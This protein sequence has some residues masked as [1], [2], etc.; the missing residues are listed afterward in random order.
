MY[1]TGNNGNNGNNNNGN[2]R[3]NN[4]N[5]DGFRIEYINESE[6]GENYRENYQVEQDQQTGEF[7][8]LDFEKRIKFVIVKDKLGYN[9]GNYAVDN[10][11]VAPYKATRE[12]IDGEVDE[13][14]QGQ[15]E[16]G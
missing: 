11:A 4:V 12:V 6:L 16:E 7:Y 1:I 3:G 5:T 9:L 10:L 8:I 14:Q 2:N 15:Q 13:G